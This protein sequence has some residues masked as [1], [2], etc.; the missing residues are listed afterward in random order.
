MRQ[1]S[2]ADGTPSSIQV[3]PIQGEHVTAVS[4][5]LQANLNPDIEPRR[6]ERLMEPPWGA[7][8]PNRG[9]Q[10]LHD[11]DVVGVYLAV[12]ST[13][14]DGKIRVCNL[15]AFCV[16]PDY[17]QHSLRLIR[18]LTRQKDWVITDLSPSGVVPDL[19]SRLGFE[20]FDVS[21]RLVVNRPAL[22]RRATMISDPASVLE[23]LQGDDRRVYLDHRDAPASRHLVVRD[24]DSY[25]YVVYRRSRWKR[26]RVFAT[27][28]FVGGDPAVL[29]RSW[30]S[31]SAHLLAQ[32][33]IG[34]LAERRILGFAPRGPG[35]DLSHP[36][37]KMFKGG[38]PGKRTSDDL[39]SELTLLE[40]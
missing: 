17:R 28:L 2:L 21:T 36:R 33:M 11:G 24:G 39:Y 16:A 23:I 37:P 10:L 34:T 20:H 40:W 9:F 7:V 25:G 38:D 26:M 27:V 35:R 1:H 5:F 32:G 12:Y 8:G 6:W 14:D 4:A 18:A 31:I 15:A 13:H 19:N 30:T 22:R 3:C 29:D